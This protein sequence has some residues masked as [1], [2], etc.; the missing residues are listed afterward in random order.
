MFNLFTTQTP[1]PPP[2]PR[3]FQILPAESNMSRAFTAFGI[4]LL[5]MFMSLVNIFSIV[6]SPSR[7]VL[8]FTMAVISALVGLAFWSG[9]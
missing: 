1:P 5:L 3:V 4:A 7:F 9:P 6:T 2:V 8:I